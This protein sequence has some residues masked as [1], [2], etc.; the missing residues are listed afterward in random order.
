MRYFCPYLDKRTNGQRHPLY[1]RKAYVARHFC[2]YYKGRTDGRK[3]GWTDRQ[4][5]GRMNASYYLSY[6]EECFLPL[7]LLEHAGVSVS[8]SKDR[9]TDGRTNGRT[10]PFNR[11]MG[12]NVSCSLSFWR[13]PVFPSV[14]QRKD[15]LTDGR[16]PERTD[17]RTHPFNRR[18]GR[19]VSR[20]LGFW[21]MPAFPSVLCKSPSV[22]A[23]HQVFRDKK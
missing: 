13:T 18:M 10:H 8:S 16:T 21:S 23:K 3:E 19:N 14:L 11:R 20:L 2:Q 15:G 1:C 17:T 4:T 9:S 5:D 6:G 22:I 7:R 12:R